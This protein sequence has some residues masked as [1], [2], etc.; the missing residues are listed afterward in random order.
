M[1]QEL[2]QNMKKTNISEEEYALLA[3]FRYALR[4][5]MNFSKD[6][7]ESVHLT[8]KQHQA[9]LAV[10]GFGTKISPVTVGDVAEWLQIRHHSAVG[11]INRLEEQELLHREHAENDK[12]KVNIVL[13]KKGNDIL[14]KLTAVHKEEIRRIGPELRQLLRHL[15][16]DID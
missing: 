11:L 5:F 12:R 3:E 2:V 9:M 8:P 14:D 16:D 15:S 7:A 10:R 4:R 6:E 1:C 13:T